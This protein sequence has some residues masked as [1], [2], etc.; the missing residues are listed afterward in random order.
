MTTHSKLKAKLLT[1]VGTSVLASLIAGGSFAAETTVP[2]FAT[3][4]ATGHKALLSSVSNNA[5]I[6]AL[7]TG[8]TS[9]ITVTG[10]QTGTSNSVTENTV[11]AAAT[12]NSFANLIDLSLIADSPADGV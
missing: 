3:A 4:V 2:D 11:E 10:T 7:A 9:G 6:G 1:G 8:Q 5:V 12:A